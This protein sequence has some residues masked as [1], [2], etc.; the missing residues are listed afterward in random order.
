MALPFAI[1]IDGDDDDGD[2]D[3]EE[4][5][6][7]LLLDQKFI[8]TKC[9]ALRIVHTASFSSCSCLSCSAR[10]HIIIVLCRT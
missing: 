6:G 1:T 3:E 7:K 4:S 10:A 9:T 2:D 8:I 5:D